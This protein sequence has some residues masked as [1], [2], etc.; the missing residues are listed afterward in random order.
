MKIGR[1]MAPAA[2]ILSYIVAMR[3]NE[4]VCK[5]RAWRLSLDKKTTYYRSGM[6]AAGSPGAA[7]CAAFITMA[8]KV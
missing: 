4:D 8:R 1:Q 7:V 5:R 6:L 2:S 3:Q